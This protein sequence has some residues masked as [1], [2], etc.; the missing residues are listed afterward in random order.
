MQPTLSVF[1][2]HILPI[3]PIT[4]DN[5]SIPKVRIAAVAL[6]VKWDQLLQSICDTAVG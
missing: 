6:T 2:S 3:I 5:T 1:S 4:L